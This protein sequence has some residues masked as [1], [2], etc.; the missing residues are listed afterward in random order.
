MKDKYLQRPSH[1]KQFSIESTVSIYNYLLHPVQKYYYK[2]QNLQLHGLWIGYAMFTQTH[3]FFYSFSPTTKILS[4]T[5]KYPKHIRKPGQ[6][7]SIRRKRLQGGGKV[8]SGG[9]FNVTTK[10]YKKKRE[11]NWDGLECSIWG[12]GNSYW[13]QCATERD[14]ELDWEVVV[15][16]W[17]LG[18]RGN[19]RRLSKHCYWWKDQRNDQRNP[20]FICSHRS[21]LEVGERTLR[22]WWRVPPSKTTKRAT[23]R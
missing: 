18:E 13:E 11:L 6:E 4:E 2:T 23:A 19:L 22:A 10:S 21:P 1:F 17:G 14:W 20:G 12:A 16:R 8:V 5:Q 9:K 15:V 7:H 3:Y